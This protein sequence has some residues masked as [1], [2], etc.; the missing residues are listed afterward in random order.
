[1]SAFKPAIT[2]KEWGD[3]FPTSILEAPVIKEIQP[4]WS[5]ASAI[6]EDDCRRLFYRSSAFELPFDLQSDRAENSMGIRFVAVLTVNFKPGGKVSDYSVKVGYFLD[7][8]REWG[9][10]TQTVV[11]HGHKL[12]KGD[13]LVILGRRG[14]KVKGWYRE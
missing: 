10:I 13:A 7:S 1:M 2:I 3:Q 8:V 14:I 9:W 6:I 5:Q 12:Y 4:H 11:D